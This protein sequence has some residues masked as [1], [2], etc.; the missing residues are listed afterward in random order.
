M[1]TTDQ[2]KTEA[3]VG[4]LF[5]AALGSLDLLTVYVGDR[6]GL[7]K[8]LVEKGPA[9]SSELAR[10][11]K[12]NERYAR[13]WL[14]QQAVTGILD[15]DDPKLPEGKRRYALPAAHA[16]ALVDPES[17]FS[18]APLAKMLGAIGPSMPKLVEAFRTGGGVSWTDFG[19]EVMEAQGDF[20]RPWLV[21][22]FG[23]EYLPCI[24]DI[25]KRL[26]AT[27]PARVADVACGVGWSS[28]AIA[29][30]YPKAIVH[31]FD[32]DA[33]SI[34]A[35]RKNAVGAGVGDRVKFQVKD[36]AALS[37]RDKYDLAVVI[38]A[39]HDLS[40][41][42]EVLSAIRRILAPGGSLIVAD[43]RVADAFTAPG[44]DLER[45]MYG[46]SIFV[47]LPS[48]MAEQPSAATGTVMR[49]PTLK[50]YAAKAG[51]KDVQALPIQNP[52]LR[53]YRLTPS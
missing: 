16:A 12:V 22:Q 39:V 46:A 30:A 38:E 43:E 51:F 20:N 33:S 23:K 52:F 21:H 34:A 40:K 6:L 29:R 24:P 35:A 11:A 13:E 7:Y 41:P 28:I 53:F 5:N 48:G 37:S 17:P 3:F 1:T 45:M 14:E 26:R 47:C 25:H 15:V 49:A 19:N 50:G 32:L 2:A 18:F 44:D 4:R 42:V 27:P 9:T 31:G 36:V 8:T 10:R